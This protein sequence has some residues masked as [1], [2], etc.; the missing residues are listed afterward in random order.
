M[1]RVS[2][3]QVCVCVWNTSERDKHT[4]LLA[5]DVPDVPFAYESCWYSTLDLR[6]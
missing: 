4:S 5:E 1:E 3:G 2:I 6:V